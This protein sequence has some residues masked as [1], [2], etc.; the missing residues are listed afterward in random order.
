[1]NQRIWKRVR[2]FIGLIFLL[3]ITLL[4]LD[5]WDIIP[6]K[7]YNYLL[8][9][10]FTPSLLKFISVLSFSVLGFLIVLVLTL[11]F[12]R[13]YCS[14]ICP[15]GLF[16]D[17]VS[18][19]GGW[20]NRKNRRYKY[21]K[22]LNVLRYGFLGITALL[23]LLGMIQLVLLLD[24]YSIFGRTVSY[25]MKP[26]LVGANNLGA[27]LLK[28][29]D[30]YTL[31][32]LDLQPIPF[33]TY[34]I[35]L[36]FLILVVRLAW[37]YG[38]LYCNTVC[39]VGTL[40]GFL[41]RYSLLKVRMNES[42]CT[43][44]GRCA[45]ACKAQCI[46][47][48]KMQIDYSRCVACF[49]CLPVC[50]DEAIAFGMKPAVPAEEGGS[51]PDMNKRRNMAGLV[52]ILAGMSTLTRGQNVPVPTQDT[53]VKEDKIYPVSPPGSVSIDN[54]TSQ[55]TACSLCVTACP[56]HVLQPSF[57]QYGLA[58][59]MQPHMDYHAGFCNFECVKC[60]EV[61]P[62][63]AI[64]PIALEA[65]KLTQLGKA[66]FI[67]DNC[68]VRTDNTDC[69]ACSEHCPTK[70]VHMIPY[71]DNLVIPEVDTSICIGCGACE[72]ACPTKPYKAIFIDGNAQHKDAE[73]PDVEEKVEAPEEFPF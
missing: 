12:G 38:R 26:V 44:C 45:A 51:T 3:C 13:V 14:A 30:V 70:A 68:I 19:V 32:K 40:L 2:L 52:G 72:Y 11:I 10:Q 47:F 43:K 17:V 15:L 42:S 46:D 67:Q 58:G 60:S 27:G 28:L 66:I 71:K 37:K 57:K 65:K 73:K 53:R 48:R 24:P 7:W 35:P 63:G 34:L 55:C 5:T 20:F 16:Q 62:T 4:F 23:L 56:T 50:K 64:L 31:A 36:F 18:R 39:P 49:N 41:S 54:F 69:G 59:M 22:P 25:F 21:R 29:V 61:C 1:M 6:E 9:L 33:L 8:Y